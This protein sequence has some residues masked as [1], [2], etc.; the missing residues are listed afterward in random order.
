MGLITLIAE[1]RRIIDLENGPDSY[2]YNIYAVRIGDF[3]FAGTPGEPFTEIARRIYK[4]SPFNN[5]MLCCLTNASCGYLANGQAYE[6]GGYE[7][8]ASVYKAGVG[9]ILAKGMQAL[10]KELKQSYV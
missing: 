4:E 10:L 2:K 5:M 7:V 6:E 1:A 8:R 3:V 9:D